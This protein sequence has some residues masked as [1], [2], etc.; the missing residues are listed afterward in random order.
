MISP[1]CFNK[2][3]F[4]YRLAK[5]N[6]VNLKQYQEAHK[7]KSKY[8]NFRNQHVFIWQTINRGG[9]SLW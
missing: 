1:N 8:H 5:T 9:V 7:L 6:T 2:V 3:F 4:M